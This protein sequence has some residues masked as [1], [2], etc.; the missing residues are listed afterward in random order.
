M[1]NKLQC[2]KCG[3]TDSWEFTS[4]EYPEDDGTITID[5]GCARCIDEMC[6]FVEAR[7]EY[8][9]DNNQ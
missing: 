3:K 8:L 6:D 1:S 2:A 5:Y 4:I 9:E 7:A